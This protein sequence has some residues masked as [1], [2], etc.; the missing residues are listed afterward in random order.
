MKEPTPAAIRRMV[1]LG[2]SLHHRGGLEAFCERAESAINRHAEGW[3]AEWWPTNTAYFSWRRSGDLR[4]TWRRLAALDGVDL[5]W[6]Q[7]S[8]LLDLLFLRRIKSLG[9]PVLVTP[10][11]GAASRLQSK[12]ALRRLSVRLLACADRLGLLFDEQADEIALPSAIPRATI[13]TFLPED[14]LAAGIAAQGDG[15]LRL[16]HAGRLSAEKGTFRMVALCAMLQERGVPFTAQIVGRAAPDIMQALHREIE[17]TGLG[18]VLTVSSWMEEP[19]LRN[20]L[21]Q[22]DVLVHLSELDS[23]PLIVLEALVSGTFPVVSNMAGAASMVRRYGG[24]VADDSSVEGAADW[25]V[26]QDGAKLRRDADAAALRVRLDHDWERMV[27]R[28]EGVAEIM[29]APLRSADRG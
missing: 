12:P 20:V 3:R 15:P 27:H 24:F 6:L 7:W 18:D 10:H 19:A 29:L 17:K 8:T 21:R 28:I 26:G 5:V 13:G 11:L 14:T 16:I 4:E 22:A 23:Y 25:L 1:V 2:G 9:V